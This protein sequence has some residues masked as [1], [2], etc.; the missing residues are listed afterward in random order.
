MA[1]FEIARLD[2]IAPTRCPC[3]WAKRAFAEQGNA[4]SMH[5]VAIEADSRTHY[6]RKMTEIYLILEGE[7]LSASSQAESLHL[8]AEL[9]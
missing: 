7:V 4:A 6:H 5:V 2:E 3:G 9:A 1:N 8:V